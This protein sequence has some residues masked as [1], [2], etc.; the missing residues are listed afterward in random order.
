MAKSRKLVHVETIPMRWGDMDASG[1]VGNAAHFRYMEQAR[2]GW[3]GAMSCMGRLNGTGPVVVTAHCRFNRRLG[4]PG[5]IEVKTY[6]EAPGRSSVQSI[7]EL[8]LAG[9][10][11]VYAE[12]GA[13][14]VWVD[15]ARGKSCAL[16][17]P[18]RAACGMEE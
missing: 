11:A 16:P 5:T 3:F 7:Y 17:D 6:V 4:Y 13:K 14:I 15:F 1:A 9:E 2:I 12:G 8:R 10:D 18:L